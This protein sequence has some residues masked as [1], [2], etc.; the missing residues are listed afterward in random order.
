VSS[1]ARTIYFITHPDVAIDPA[2]PVQD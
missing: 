1:V 2:I